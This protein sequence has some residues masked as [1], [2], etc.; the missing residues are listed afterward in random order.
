MFVKQVE[1]EAEQFAYGNLPGWCAP[2]GLATSSFS[3][4]CSVGVLALDFFEGLGCGL[5]SLYD[6]SYRQD[7]WNGMKVCKHCGRN[8]GYSLLNICSFGSFGWIKSNLNEPSMKSFVASLNL[9]AYAAHERINQLKCQMIDFFMNDGLPNDD[10][11]VKLDPNALVDEDMKAVLKDL[12]KDVNDDDLLDDLYEQ[13]F[14]DVYQ[15][16][17]SDDDD[18]DKFFDAE[19]GQ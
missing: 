16:A 18:D 1:A 2:V 13:V 4:V 17:K 8:I 11:H 15:P 19:G 5:Y 3:I 14:P 7:F 6:K 10:V 12:Y 9:D